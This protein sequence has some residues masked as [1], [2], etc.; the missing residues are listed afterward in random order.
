MI[1]QI[2]ARAPQARQARR[3][4]D[5]T[6]QE[7]EEAV[8]LGYVRAVAYLKGCDQFFRPAWRFLNALQSLQGE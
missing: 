7:M 8:L 5:Q 2:A 6:I 3:V 4:P 1:P